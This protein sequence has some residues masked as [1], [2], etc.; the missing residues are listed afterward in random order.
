MYII[1]TD[2]CNKITQNRQ[3]VGPALC[4]SFREVVLRIS[5]Q[6]FRLLSL[7]CLCLKSGML[8]TYNAEPL[9]HAFPVDVFTGTPDLDDEGGQEDGQNDD[10][11][12]EAVVQTWGNSKRDF[13]LFK[14]I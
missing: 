1:H 10:D 6:L 5:L 3:T 2:M 4:G 13:Y 8:R 9:G 11:S 12:R 14:Q 7:Y